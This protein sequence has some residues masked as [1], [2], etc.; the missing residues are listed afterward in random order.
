MMGDSFDFAVIAQRAG[1][2]GIIYK[3]KGI[4]SEVYVVFN[5]SQIKSK[6]NRGGFNLKSTSI[7]KSK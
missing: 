7:F 2:D 3:P 1:Y 4:D 6:H 5:S